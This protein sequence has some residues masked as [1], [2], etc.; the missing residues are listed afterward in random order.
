MSKENGKRARLYEYAVLYH[1]EPEEVGGKVVEKRSELIV[2]LT[3]V[4]ATSEQEVLIQA[5]RV[6]PEQYLDKL[7][8]VE[9]AVRPF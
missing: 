7:K 9:I 1:P 8:G 6:I 5:S 3:T 4:L 2:D